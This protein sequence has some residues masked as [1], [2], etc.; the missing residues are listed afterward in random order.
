MKRG[1]SEEREGGM[2]EEEE[3]EAYLHLVPP[4]CPLALLLLR[5]FGAGWGPWR[6]QI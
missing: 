3:E 4:Y 1:P 6:W 2:Q 5:R